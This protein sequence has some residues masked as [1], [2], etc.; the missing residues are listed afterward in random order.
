MYLVNVTE[1]VL[2]AF[3]PDCAEAQKEGY[4]FQVYVDMYVC[5]FG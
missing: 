5:I 3:L 1:H 4:M 2:V